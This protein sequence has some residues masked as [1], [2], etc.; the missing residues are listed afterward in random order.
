VGT[1]GKTVA[2]SEDHKPENE[3]EKN[4]VEA[5]GGSIKNGRVDG[6]LGVSRGF[7]DGLYKQ[8]AEIDKIAQ[9]ITPH[10]DVTI[11]TRNHET[12][13]VLVLACD[14]LWDVSESHEAVEKI[15]DLY[16]SGE[17]SSLLLAEEL[18]HGALF[19]GQSTDNISAV[20]CIL[21]AAKFGPKEKGGVKEIRLERE[22]EKKHEYAVPKHLFD[23]LIG[24]EAP[25]PQPGS[26][27]Y[28]DKDEDY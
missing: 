12:D 1:A 22:L 19:E 11:Y 18:V 28:N 8:N 9:K 6:N 7:G 14:G 10:P 23:Y 4:R 16:R 26:L 20:V 21:P 3:Q 2:L 25:K 15:R 24:M 17:Q 5:A 27:F 13:D